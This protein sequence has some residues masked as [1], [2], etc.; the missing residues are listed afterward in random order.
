MQFDPYLSSLSNPYK[1][2]ARAGFALARYPQVLAKLFDLNTHFR[3]PGP[4]S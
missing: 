2:G 3:M 4:L 1:T